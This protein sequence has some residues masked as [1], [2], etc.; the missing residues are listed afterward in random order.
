MRRRGRQGTTH[1]SSEPSSAALC[2]VSSAAPMLAFCSKGEE[3]EIHTSGCHR[4][5]QTIHAMRQLFGEDRVGAQYALATDITCDVSDWDFAKLW[6]QCS[7]DS[8][9]D[10]AFRFLFHS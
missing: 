8:W 3:K 6:S 7:V 5:A 4:C 2:R 1:T 10:H 9:L